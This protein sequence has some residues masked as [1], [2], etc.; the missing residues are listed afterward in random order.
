MVQHDLQWAP[1]E[2]SS[3]QDRG[4]QQPLTVSILWI[5]KVPCCRGENLD[6]F[7]EFLIYNEHERSHPCHAG[8][9]SISLEESLSVLILEHLSLAIHSAQIC[10]VQ[11]FPGRLHHMSLLLPALSS[12][13]TTLCMLLGSRNMPHLAVCFTLNFAAQ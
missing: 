10:D 9:W 7:F 6:G 2:I 8:Y 11:S 4:S 5:L 13:G 12:S 3:G 1:L